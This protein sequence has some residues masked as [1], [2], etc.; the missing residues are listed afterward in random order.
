MLIE[1]KNSPKLQITYLINSELFLICRS[2]NILLDRGSIFL[3]NPGGASD[4][5][6]Y[7]LK[8]QRLESEYVEWK[9]P[10]ISMTEKLIIH[11]IS[12]EF[13]FTDGSIN[14][15]F[16]IPVILNHEDGEKFFQWIIFVKSRH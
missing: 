3:Q 14:I 2:W 10:L 7:S 4:G 5:Q 1:G 13:A 12:I 8:N 9:T 11:L 16:L 15:C 6:D